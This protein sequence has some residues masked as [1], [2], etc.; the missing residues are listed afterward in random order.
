MGE[1]S[2]NRALVDGQAERLFPPGFQDKSGLPVIFDT[3]NLQG[4][5]QGR[6]PK[7]ESQNKNTTL[8]GDP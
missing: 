6:G 5:Q 2:Y 8:R 1:N 7:R 3:F 4:I